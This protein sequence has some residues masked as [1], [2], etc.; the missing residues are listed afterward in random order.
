MKQITEPDMK[1]SS[2]WKYLPLPDEPDRHDESDSRN[3]ISPE[4]YRIVGARA[5][6]KKHKHEGTHCD[7]WFD[8]ATSGN[9]TIFALSDGAGSSRL[10]RVGA[11]VSCEAAVQYLAESLKDCTLDGC[12]L[13]DAAAS[14]GGEETDPAAEERIHAVQAALH[15]SMIYAHSRVA[16]AF[17]QRRALEEYRVLLGGREPVLSDF[18]ATLLVALHT[19]LIHEGVRRSYATA[20]QIGDG[21]T[22]AIDTEGHL[23]LLGI[24]DSGE[25]SGETEFLTSEDMLSPSTLMRKT[26]SY[27][28][29]LRALI[30]MSDGV[31]DD[32][33]PHSYG[34]KRLFGD[35]IINGIIAPSDDDRG[36]PEA[37]SIPEG[38]TAPA[39]LEE[40]EYSY[41]AETA[42]SHGIRRFRIRSCERLSELSGMPL[43]SF[44]QRP[45]LM[46]AWREHDTDKRD[47]AE[48]LLEWLDSYYVRGSFDDR[49]LL[50]LY[51]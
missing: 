8:F 18:S 4:G 50:L 34:L 3:G 1:S 31:A 39:L 25:F 30:T 51:R 43:E 22:A 46:Q 40:S 28:G 20:C 14:S 15:E 35:L 11:R 41:V 38:E 10:S 49:T 23:S 44:I 42:A 45:A 29:S 12:H 37:P 9:W 47:E 24:P 2:L 33:F 7:D 48:M 6:G 19:S 21:I 5:R 32:Y 13:S 16:E 36:A 27:F 26:V 17:E